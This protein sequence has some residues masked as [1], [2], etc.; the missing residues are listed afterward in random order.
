M[1]EKHKED[2]FENLK[3]RAVARDCSVM[4]VVYIC[5]PYR[6]YTGLNEHNAKRYCSFA[7]KQGCIPFAPHL[8]YPQ[9]LDD[10]NE[11]ERRIGIYA[12][13]YFLP[14]CSELW[15]FGDRISDGM[16]TEMR[17]AEKRRI[18]IRRFTEDCREISEGGAI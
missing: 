14:S 1:D 8:L 5:S 13:L 3:G 16:R 9:F 10:G 17:K 7:V 15:V 6:G 18:P 4:P 12:G 11:D 2:K